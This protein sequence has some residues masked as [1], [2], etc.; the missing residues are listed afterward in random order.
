MTMHD[1]A[2]SLDP[3]LIYLNH[4]AVA[5][6]PNVTV[7]AASRF[8]RENGH[9]GALDYPR[10]M[11]TESALRA[12]LARLINAPSSD[13]IALLKSTSEG[14]S[15]VAHGLAW[16]PGDNLVTI[17]QEFPSNRI[18]WQSL[19]TKGV[20]VRLLDL[21][22]H[23]DPEQALM[24]LCDSN[25]RLLAVSSVQ[26]ASGRRMQIEKLGE[27]CQARGILFV[28]DAIQSLGAL[29]FDVAQNHADAVVADG[30]KW[31]LGPEGLALFYSRPELR[32]RLSLNQY[33]W[34]M[35]E[36]AWDFEATEWQP[37]K[38]ARRF[39]CGSP[40][41]LGAHA[42]LASLDLLL[43]IGI[44][45]VFARIEEN[46][47]AIVEQIRGH[48]FELLSP[49]KP[50][51]RAGIITFRVPGADTRSLQQGLMQQRVVCAE[52]GGGIRFSPH[53]HN[54]SE[55]IECAFAILDRLQNQT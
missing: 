54:T 47:Q 30:H 22:Q 12:S 34:H 45:Q 38:S 1:N 27:F 11:K 39:E 53:F 41:M 6:W 49:P 55:Q 31:M 50:A 20:E 2:F 18:V 46:T 14:L 52:R 13:D 33:G 7:E 28:I 5:P 35:V 8:A 21:S 19:E 9:T 16:N 3:D 51:L 32:E 24:A 29:P 40:N 10:W 25:T 42:L 15:V 17:A 43:D 26:Y 37:A 44:E 23:E 48:K 4:A 36:D